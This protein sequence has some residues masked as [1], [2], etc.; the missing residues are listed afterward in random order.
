MVVIMSG[1]LIIA[2]ILALVFLTVVFTVHLPMK[3]RLRSDD[4]LQ[5]QRRAPSGRQIAVS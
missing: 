5:P 3:P 2:L 1:L 4:R